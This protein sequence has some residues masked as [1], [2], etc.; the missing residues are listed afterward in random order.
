MRILLLLLLL[1]FSK[2]ISAQNRDYFKNIEWL[3]SFRSEHIAIVSLEKAD[4]T[5]DKKLT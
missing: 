5:T 1:F 2:S 4:H 3:I